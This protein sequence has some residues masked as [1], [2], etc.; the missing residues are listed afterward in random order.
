MTARPT[1]QVRV[2]MPSGKLATVFAS[3]DLQQ[4]WKWLAR[5]SVRTRARGRRWLETWDA[6]AVGR[7]SR[8]ACAPYRLVRG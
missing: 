2:L 5:G 7:R 3:G 4:V 1:Y 8:A 6:P